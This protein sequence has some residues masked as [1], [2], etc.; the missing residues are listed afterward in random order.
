MKLVIVFLI[1]ASLVFGGA[2][3]AQE[4]GCESAFAD[5]N[6]FTAEVYEKSTTEIVD[7]V[8]AWNADD[9][10]NIVRQV[11]GASEFFL[12]NCADPDVPLWEQLDAVQQLA[13]MSHI[14]PP[15]ESVDIGGDFGEVQLIT[16]F[17]PSTGFIDF[18]GDGEGEMFLNTQVPYFSE[19]TV[20]MIQGGLTIAFFKDAADGW[21]GQ[22]I[23]PVTEFVTTQDGP[24]LTYAQTEDNT[25][26]VESAEQ[27]L[28]IFPAPEIQVVDVDGTPLT[29]ITTHSL[30]GAGEAKELDVLSW[31]GRIPSVELRVAFDDW[32]YPGAALDWTIGDDGSVSIPSNGNEEGSPLHCGRTPEALYTWDGEGYV[33][34][35]S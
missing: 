6:A 1:L 18:N 9:W 4:G 16:N 32:C 24:H 13:A 10:V 33:L 22:V 34:A 17:K 20:Y 8:I 5:V 14:L 23:A 25:L 11:V 31:D 3:M 19:K 35:E 28:K 2:A 12:N 26:S 21:Q 15:V 7:G 30:T 27:A 29:F